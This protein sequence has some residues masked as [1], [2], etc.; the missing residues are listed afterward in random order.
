MLLTF[1]NVKGAYSLRHHQVT[2]LYTEIDI[3]VK[4]NATV[5]L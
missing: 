3:H 4:K 1:L 2:N 5:K